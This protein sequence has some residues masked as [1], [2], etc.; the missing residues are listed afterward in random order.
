MTLSL[1]QWAERLEQ[2]GHLSEALVA[3]QQYSAQTPDSIE[4]LCAIAR[5]YRQKEELELARQSLMDALEKAPNHAE[6]QFELGRL[7]YQT[8]QFEYAVPYLQ[9]ALRLNPQHAKAYYWLGRIFQQEGHDTMATRYYEQAV[10]YDPTYAEALNA[11]GVVSFVQGDT[12]QAKEV[13]AQAVALNPQEADYHKHYGLAL[14]WQKQEAESYAHLL[15][16]IELKPLMAEEYLNLGEFFVRERKMVAANLFFKLALKGSGV[17]KAFLYSRLGECA[18]QESEP[19]EALY[20]YQR[21]IQ[22]KPEDWWPEIR[23]ATLLPWI[24]QSSE[25]VINWNQRYATHLESLHARLSHRKIPPIT[26]F[27]QN[28]L[29]AYQGL[30]N[31]TLYEKL[32]HFWLQISPPLKQPLPKPRSKRALRIGIVSAHFFKH[33]IMEC[34]GELILQ[35]SKTD[36]E[37]YC[38]QVGHPYQDQETQKLKNQVHHFIDLS[39]ETRSDIL[40]ENIRKQALDI[41]IY[42]EIGLE[43]LTYLLALQRLAPVQCALTGHPVTSGSPAIDY[44][45]SCSLFEPPQAQTHYTESL[46]CSEFP[47]LT[48]PRPELPSAILS[49]TELGLPED[50]HI[51]LAPE[52][53]FKFHPDFDALLKGILDQ[54]P[55]AVIVFIRHQYYFWHQKLAQRFENSL[56]SHKDRILFLEWTDQDKFFM[57]LLQ[58]DAVLDSL[59]FG[60]GTVAYQALGLGVPM[61]TLPGSMMRGRIVAGLYHQMGIRDCWAQTREEYIQIAC[62]LANDRL[63]KKQISQ[64]IK[65]KNN[66]LFESSAG[67]QEF[68][69]FLR[70]TVQE[71]SPS[72]IFPETD[73]V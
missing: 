68:I 50:K 5:I 29:L 52:S 13:L 31:R 63:W 24:Y 51:Y 61:V 10:C 71:S 16:A 64:K 19:D 28:F 17:S 66:C 45:I 55:Q 11:W 67:T 7:F 49:R 27:S 53:L 25:D 9:Q 22:Q 70:R 42:P 2:G 38:I 4:S 59:Y 56:Q 20:F 69:S 39:T 35:L 57:R 3:F 33:P 12:E 73:Q 21:A 65:N 43:N 58:A 6:V 18:E 44:F 47:I 62:K 8:G 36:F 48:I 60:A 54:D 30:N 34:F 46:F 41:L 23:A 32:A 15:K 40:A 37:I 72:G 26:H 14:F 1:Q